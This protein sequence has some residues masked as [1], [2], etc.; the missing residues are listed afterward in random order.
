MYLETLS[1]GGDFR[2]AIGYTTDIFTTGR[3]SGAYLCAYNLYTAHA[4]GANT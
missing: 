4:A 1:Q 3:I 2:R